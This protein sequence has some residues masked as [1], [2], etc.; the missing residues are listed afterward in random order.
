MINFFQPIIPEPPVRPVQE[1]KRKNKKEVLYFDEMIDF[2]KMKKIKAKIETIP[3]KYIYFYED[4]EDQMGYN[5]TKELTP[6]A[7]G[8]II[9]DHEIFEKIRVDGDVIFENYDMDYSNNLACVV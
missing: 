1:Q 6:K 7:K 5:I 3:G 4:W 2:N 9:T 8:Y